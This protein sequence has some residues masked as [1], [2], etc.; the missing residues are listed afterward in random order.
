MQSDPTARRE[1]DRAGAGSPVEGEARGP[2]KLHDDA[3]AP[4]EVPAA[5]HDDA[6]ARHGDAAARHV[7]TAARHAA[8][9]ARR[10][11][12]DDSANGDFNIFRQPWL[13]VACLLLVAS[14]VLLLLSRADAAFVCAALGVSAWF[15]NVRAGLKRKHDLVK[16]SGR[17]WVQ[18]GDE[19]DE[20]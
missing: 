18:R 10:D 14:V 3:N 1:D 15:W 2:T 20:D 19:E 6:A 12:R 17:N 13:V 4:R 11:D 9:A 8:P 5:P 7:D 16:A